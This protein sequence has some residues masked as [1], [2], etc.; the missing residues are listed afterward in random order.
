VKIREELAPK[1]LRATSNIIK[2]RRIAI[3]LP[4]AKE[5]AIL[6]TGSQAD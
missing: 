5:D 1:D 3:R 4:K 2:R 6:L